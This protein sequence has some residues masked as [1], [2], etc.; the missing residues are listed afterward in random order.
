MTKPK[1]G[2]RL[3]CEVT[4]YEGKTYFCEVGNSAWDNSLSDMFDLFRSLLMGLG[5]AERQIGE[6]LNPEDEEEPEAKVGM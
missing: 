3:S 1:Q 4:D 5:Y 6:W 2:T